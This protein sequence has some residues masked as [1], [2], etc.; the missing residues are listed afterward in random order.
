MTT[1]ADGRTMKT[2]LVSACLLGEACRYD[3]AS[4]PSEVVK[5][6]CEENEV[7]PVCPEVMGGLP[8]PRDP[9]ERVGERVV[10]C[11]GHDV[12]E[13]YVCGAQLTLEKARE[14]GA[15]LAILKAKSPS[16]GAGMI[17]DGTFTGHLVAGNGVTAEL[18]AAH[19]ITVLTEDELDFGRPSSPCG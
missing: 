13:Q 9:S 8:T 18:L 1:G 14:V 16:C 2:V 5:R 6:F 11:S 3:G 7:I 10:S 19:G 12:T 17:Y 15:Q 4:R